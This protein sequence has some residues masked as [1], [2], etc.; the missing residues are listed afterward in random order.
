MTINL[1]TFN[2]VQSNTF[3]RISIPGYAT[4]R[5]SDYHKPFTIAGENYI[6]LGQLVSVTET[7]SNL[8]AAPQEVSVV[9]G[10]IPITNI[11]DI[12]NNRIKGSNIRIYRTLFDVTTGN[13]L[14]VNDNPSGKFQGVVSNFVIN[15]EID[16][17]SDTGTIQLILTCTSVVEL[18]S[19]KI[20]GR[21]TNPLDMKEWY[22]NDL[23][24]D[25]IPS[26][27]KSNFNFGA[28]QT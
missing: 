22:P 7:S 12:L 26:L 14:S 4:L 24:F 28:P 5:F 21:R 15:D 13:V 2:A 25:R 18:L 17:G 19:N 11:A 20:S 27:A 23:S 3:V 9:I 8:R 1:S 16:S 10:G 6:A